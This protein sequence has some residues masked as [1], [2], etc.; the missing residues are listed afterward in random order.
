V[1][2]LALGRANW[3]TWVG[4]EYLMERTADAD[5]IV[6]TMFDIPVEPLPGSEFVQNGMMLPA[7]DFPGGNLGELYNFVRDNDLSFR[8]FGKS[9]KYIMKVLAM[10][11]KAGELRIDELR[12]INQAIRLTI[13]SIFNA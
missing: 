11:E 9:H 4:L 12:D 2:P 5:I 8:Q 13:A 3:Q 7:P 1:K 6:T 10:V